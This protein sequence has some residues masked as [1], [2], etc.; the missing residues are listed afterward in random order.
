MGVVPG[1]PS[2]DDRVMASSETAQVS[3]RSPKSM[4]PS[5]RGAAPSIR[6]TTTL[7][8][9]RSMCAAWRGRSSAS[10]AIRAHAAAAAAVKRSR[11][12]W[13]ATCETRASTTSWPWRRSHCSA[14]SRPGWLKPANA[15]LTLAATLAHA[16]NHLGRQVP[17]ADQRAAGQVSQQSDVGGAVQQIRYR[18]ALLTGQVGQR[19]RDP[20]RRL[21]LGDQLGGRVLRCQ[22]DRRE[23]RVGD[24]QHAEQPVL[25]IE[26]QEVLVLLAAKRFR[27][28]GQ[29]VVD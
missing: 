27:A 4:T 8:S 20:Q 7:A 6:V 3:E 26:H 5:G 2:T 13:S 23:R 14:R 16:G 12:D 28:G 1:W 17:G 10:G 18:R 25:G 19:H 9:V 24:L 11:S 15:R 22:L 29:S 21:R